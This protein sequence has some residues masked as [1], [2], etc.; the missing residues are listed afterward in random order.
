MINGP[1]Q[2]SVDFHITIDVKDLVTP[3]GSGDGTAAEEALLIEV[4]S[5]V[6]DLVTLRTYNRRHRGSRMQTC[7]KAGLFG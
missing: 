4:W 1:L 2:V 7:I 6:E 3:Q 5:A